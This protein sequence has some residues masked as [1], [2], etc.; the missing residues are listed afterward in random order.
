MTDFT[1]YSVRNMRVFK[2]YPKMWSNIYWRWVGYF[3]NSSFYDM[4]T[5]CLT[6]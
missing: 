5:I 3:N 2:A 6:V 1:K 4:K